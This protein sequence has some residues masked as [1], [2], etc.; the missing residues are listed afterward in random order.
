MDPYCFCVFPSIIGMVLFRQEDS[1]PR[2][3]WFLGRFELTGT[4]L[5]PRLSWHD[6]VVSSNRDASTRIWVLIA[7][8]SYFGIQIT[9]VLHTSIES[10][11]I[12]L[13]H[14]VMSAGHTETIVHIKAKPSRYLAGEVDYWFGRQLYRIVTD[15]SRTFDSAGSVNPLT[16]S[17]KTKLEAV[18]CFLW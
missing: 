13:S 18:S 12:F 7:D 17:W 8:R 9:T 14:V 2:V 11:P 15:D 1:L 4:M 6:Q 16:R 10:L 5:S 3:T